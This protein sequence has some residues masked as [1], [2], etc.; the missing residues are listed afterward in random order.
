M[1]L[2]DMNLA[3]RFCDQVLM[4]FGDGELP[5]AMRRRYSPQRSSQRLYQTPVRVLPWAGGTAF[6]PG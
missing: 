2:H 6:L 5:A 4:L 3:A 1:S